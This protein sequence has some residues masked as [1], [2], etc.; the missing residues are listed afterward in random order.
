MSILIKNLGL[1]P[2]QKTW[3]AMR[4]FTLERTKKTAD[5]IWLVE[6]PAVFTQGVN[7]KAEH[8]LQPSTNIPI[9]QTDRGGQITF[10]APGQLIVYILLDLKRAK[11][12]IRELIN[13]LEKII[14]QLLSSYNI[15]SIARKDA[16]GVYVNQK[17]IASLGLKVRKHRTYH[18]LSLNIKMDLTPFRQINPCGLQG[19][20]MTQLA[21]HIKNVDFNQVL[22][23]LAQLLFQYYNQKN[24]L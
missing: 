4:D 21:D 7:G 3:Q 13:D 18:G 23:H 9:I 17:K 15:Q 10:H 1:Q 12:G 11:I 14:I 5:E 2:Y 19:I 16:P 20:Q 24:P 8:I 22:E 6:H